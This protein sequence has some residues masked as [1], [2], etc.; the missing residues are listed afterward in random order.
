[1]VFFDLYMDE[2][3]SD[4]KMY[5]HPSSMSRCTQEEWEAVW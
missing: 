1:M 2:D 3:N 4:T 5:T